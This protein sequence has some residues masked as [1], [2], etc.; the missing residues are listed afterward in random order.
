MKD[1]KNVSRA[2][3][4][5]EYALAR[6]LGFKATS[7][8][9]V[10]KNPYQLLKGGGCLVW[11][12]GNLIMLTDAAVHFGEDKLYL[13]HW[14]SDH[15]N[16][17]YATVVSRQKIY[18]DDKIIIKNENYYRVAARGMLKT[19]AEYRGV[20]ISQVELDHKNR[21]RGDNRRCNLRPADSEQNNWNRGIDKIEGAFYTIEDYI[22]KR[23]SGEWVPEEDD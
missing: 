13:R 16:L 17:P 11:L 21:K 9:A 5:N 1:P 10:E 12:P 6:K 19:I 18:V 4:K 8:K 20:P 22:A 2:N 15:K 23:A 14:V 3:L 7:D